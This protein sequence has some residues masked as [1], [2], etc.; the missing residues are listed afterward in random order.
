MLINF[1]IG[2]NFFFFFGREQTELPWP[3]SRQLSAAFI[4]NSFLLINVQ[5]NT[6]REPQRNFVLDF[7]F[8][9]MLIFT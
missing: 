5:A 3:V 7:S 1:K 8:G 4:E 2:F 9:K 6:R